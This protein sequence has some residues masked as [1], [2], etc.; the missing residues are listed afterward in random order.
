VNW[1]E[2]HWVKT[3]VT[4]VL[5]TQTY[6]PAIQITERHQEILSVIAGQVASAIERFLAEREIQKF[7]LGIDR[8]DNI[9]FITDLD[10]TIQYANPAFEKIYGFTHE[11]TIGHT[12]VS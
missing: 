10:G 11:E 12:P 6:D 5:A 2:F 8:S 4:G 7:K 9:V 1:L 3:V